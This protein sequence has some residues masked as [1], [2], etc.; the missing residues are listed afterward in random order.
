MQRQKSQFNLKTEN[1]KYCENYCIK[2]SHNCV[3]GS[4][5]ALVGCKLT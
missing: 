1:T 5:F 3:P 2:L 4:F